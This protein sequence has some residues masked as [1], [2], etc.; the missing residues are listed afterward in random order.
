MRKLLQCN[1]LCQTESDYD[2]RGYNKKECYVFREQEILTFQ[3]RVENSE[4]YSYNSVAVYTIEVPTKKHNKVKV[5]EVKEKKIKNL[6][7][8]GVFEEV[9]DEGEE[10]IGWR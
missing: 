10:K 2:H 7:K 9:I 6:I 5:V 1:Q 8:Y 3:L 4:C